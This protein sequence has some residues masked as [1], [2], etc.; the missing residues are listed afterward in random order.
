MYQELLGQMKHQLLQMDNWLVLAAA[1]AEE[2]KFDV[3]VLVGMRLAP[4]QFP[5][6]RQ[7][8][9]ACDTAKLGA[10]RM[11]GKEAATQED[12]ETT[13]EQLRARIASVVRYLIS[14]TDEDFEGIEERTVTTARWEGHYMTTHDYLLE[15]MMPNVYFHVVHVYAILRHNGVNLGK[16]DYLGTL[17]KHPPAAE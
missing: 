6:A 4:N 17:S 8:Q 15:Y 5:L 11:T 9:I 7:V 10:S 14:F 2:R 1:H 16:R 13:V 3:D 12:N